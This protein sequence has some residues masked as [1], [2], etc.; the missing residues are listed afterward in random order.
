[1]TAKKRVIVLDIGTHKAQEVRLLG[2]RSLRFSLEVLW[3]LTRS[4][5]GRLQAFSDFR[6]IH[7]ARAKLS[8]LELCYCLVEPVIYRET[9]SAMRKLENFVFLKGVCSSSP[10]GP[11]ELRLSKGNLGHSI[12]PTKPNLTGETVP[13]WNYNFMDLLRWVDASMRQSPD[14]LLVLRMNAEGVEKDIIADIVSA[15][16]APRI[17]AFFGSLGDIKK[18]FGEA[19]Y[20]KAESSLAKMGI[21]FVYFTSSPRSWAQ[22]LRE[23]LSLA[24]GGSG[25][26]IPAQA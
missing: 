17:D 2:D 5:R 15:S 18:C 26:Y 14:D 3:L 22:G 23:F 9:L 25:R 11:Q 7:E 12:I 8:E 10:S 6:S 21:P 19:E 1:M 13:T 20:R 4:Y 24:T 16:D